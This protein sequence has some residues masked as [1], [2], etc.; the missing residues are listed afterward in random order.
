MSDKPG[1]SNSEWKI[2]EELWSASPR[3]LMEL[4]RAMREKYGWAKST[5]NT[6]VR[7][8]EEKGLVRYEE[9]SRSRLY[10]PCCGRADAAEA[11][12]ESFLSKVYGGSVGLLVS[13]MAGQKS[14]TEDDIEELRRILREAEEAGK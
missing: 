12:T 11:E 6:T 7:R 14:L 8:M 10:M 4:V 5:T 13:S 1:I 3:T 2:M 9:G